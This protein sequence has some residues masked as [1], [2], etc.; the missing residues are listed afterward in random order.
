MG[1]FAGWGH[2]RYFDLGE[3][4]IGFTTTLAEI[5]KVGNQWKI[6]H[7][8]KPTAY[9]SDDNCNGNTQ[10]GTIF[11]TQGSSMDLDYCITFP[12]GGGR[13]RLSVDNMNVGEI[14]QLPQIGEWTRV[15]LAQEFDEDEGTYFLSLSF[16]GVEMIK[17]EAD[18][19]VVEA[20]TEGTEQL[21]DVK[22][23]LGEP[24]VQIPG[25]I[26]RLVVLEKS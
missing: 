14:M 22:I 25:F 20:I 1:T 15:E 5:P 3:R 6:I 21:W 18:D 17:V 19:Y 10:P 23:E 9:L 26:R 24:D 7:D 16:D 13:V 2:L 11:V 4:E 8:F 12:V